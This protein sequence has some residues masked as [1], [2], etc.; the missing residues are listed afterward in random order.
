MT[1]CRDVVTLE[2]EFDSR[3]VPYGRWAVSGFMSIT[4][5]LIPLIPFWLL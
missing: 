2:V 1:S 5:G 3:L 4:L